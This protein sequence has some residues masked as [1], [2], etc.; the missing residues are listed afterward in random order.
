MHL[1]TFFLQIPSSAARVKNIRSGNEY[2]R[3]RFLSRLI[4][5]IMLLLRIVLSE[6][7]L[8]FYTVIATEKN[9]TLD[10]LALLRGE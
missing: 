8:W 10:A 4:L 3:L 9:R 7:V 6:F 1:I 5:K 2:K